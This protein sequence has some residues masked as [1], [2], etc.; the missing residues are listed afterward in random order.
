MSG[1]LLRFFLCISLIFW[2]CGYTSCY[3]QYGWDVK[4]ANKE[5]TKWM[6]SDPE[7]GDEDS[8]YVL[9][10]MD[11]PKDEQDKLMK[12]DPTSVDIFKRT[13]GYLNF[14]GMLVSGRRVCI[15]GKVKVYGA[16]YAKKDL[17]MEKGAAIVEDSC[18]INDIRCLNKEHF[19]KSSGEQDKQPICPVDLGDLPVRVSFMNVHEV[20]PDYNKMKDNEWYFTEEDKKDKK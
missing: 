17:V 9:P 1:R 11:R 19:D 5:Y 20:I 13:P 6:R 14:R 10:G 16:V 18:F 15:S 12:D 3:Y 4:K 8:T 2:L 7:P